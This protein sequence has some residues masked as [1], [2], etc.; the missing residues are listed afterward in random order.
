MK[1]ILIVE[2]EPDIRRIT[3]KYLVSEKYEVVEAENGLHG[4]E[5]AYQVKPDLVICDINMPVLDGYGLQE[6]LAAN[7]KTANI[8]VIFLTALPD[9]AIDQLDQ[10]HNCTFL[11]KP[12]TRT[13]LLSAVQLYLEDKWL[14]HFDDPP[15][16]VA[17][18]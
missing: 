6:Q 11:A 2:D 8:P 7:P 5:L 1:K 17:L 3:N 10:W 15:T 13:E 12:Y 18:G 16:P 9:R 4:L 14:A